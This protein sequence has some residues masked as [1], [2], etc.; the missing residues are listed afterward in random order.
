MNQKEENAVIHADSLLLDIIKAQ[1]SLLSAKEHN[2]V[3]GRK[4]GDF[5]AALRQRL[6]EMY[7]STP[8]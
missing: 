1:P 4:T 3:N 2:D 8:H 7:Q 5:I 6:I